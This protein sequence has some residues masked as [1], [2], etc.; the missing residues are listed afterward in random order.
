M[1]KIV[2]SSEAEKKFIDLCGELLGSADKKML[3]QAAKVCVI[4][5]TLNTYIQTELGHSE[6]YTEAEMK[7]KVDSKITKRKRAV[8]V[9]AANWQLK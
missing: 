7:N 4:T 9:Q 6:S 3:S 5:K 2:S 1:G 8:Q